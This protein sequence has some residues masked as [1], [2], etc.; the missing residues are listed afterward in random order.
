MFCADSDDINYKDVRLIMPALLAAAAM[1]VVDAFAGIGGGGR[2][3]SVSGVMN[4]NDHQ[5]RP[6]RPDRPTCSDRVV[7]TYSVFFFFS[8]FRQFR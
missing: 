5:F 2:W 4:Y 1:S 8:G 6:N 7:D 3:A